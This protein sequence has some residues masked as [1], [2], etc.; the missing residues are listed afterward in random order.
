MPNDSEYICE[1]GIE[2]DNQ[3]S[4][5]TARTEYYPFEKT[6]RHYQLKFNFLQLPERSFHLKWTIYYLCQLRKLFISPNFKYIFFLCSH[7]TKV[8]RF[9]LFFINMNDKCT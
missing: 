6:I 2:S 5:S 9:L 7:L 3:E 4:C 8:L 1:Y